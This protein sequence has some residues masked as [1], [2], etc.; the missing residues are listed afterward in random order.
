MASRTGNPAHSGTPLTN[1]VLVGTTIVVALLVG[2]FLSYNANQGLPFVKTFPLNVRVPDAAELVVGSE[3]RIGGFRVGQVNK[4]TAVPAKDKTPPY[5]ELKLKLDGSLTGIPADTKVQVR[6]R[7]L[8]GAKYV[9]LDPG[10]ADDVKANATLPLKQALSTPELDESFNVFDAETRRGLQG[11]IRSFGDAVAGRGSDINRSIVATDRLLPPLQRV[12]ETLADPKTDLDGFVDGA[13]RLTRALGPVADTFVELF[14]HGATTLAA[15]DA[16]GPAFGQAIEELPLTEAAAQTALDDAR[17]VIRDL[18][19]IT[20][21]LRDGADRLPATTNLLAD[22]LVS[23]RRALARTGEVTPKADTVLRTLRTI[24]ADKATSGALRKLDTTVNKL[25]PTV[26]YLTAAQTNCNV[27]GL[28]AH[29]FYSPISQGDASGTW[30]TFYTLFR[31]EQTQKAPA[32]EGDLHINPYP[33]ENASECESGNEP[34]TPG[35]FIGNPKGNQSTTTA[36]TTP[37]P[38][39][40]ERARAAG[41]LDTI[42]GASTR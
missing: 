42:P 27:A 11:T 17:P 28:F 26:K 10:T 32:P 7:S 41:L 16:A 35:Q 30:L 22:A 23:G 19:D 29:N 25:R 8:L 40:T 15:I 3:V 37:P 9:E 21:S 36:E 33:N 2:V 13:A 6:P 14:D 20:I 39:V 34:Y 31:F 5:A 1:P 4:I 12:V 24:S 18:A 38:G